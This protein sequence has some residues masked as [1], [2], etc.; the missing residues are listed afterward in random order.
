MT[1][2]Y[3]EEIDTN[4]S[5]S[6][7]LMHLNILVQNRLYSLDCGDNGGVTSTAHVVRTWPFESSRVTSSSLSPC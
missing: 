7:R 5:G 3:S 1:K 2:L 6:A 4:I